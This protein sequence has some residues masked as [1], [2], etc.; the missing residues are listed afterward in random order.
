M[1]DRLI[2]AAANG[3]TLPGATSQNIE[4]IADQASQAASLGAKL[5]LFP[6]LSLTGFL[7]NHPESNHAAWLREALSFAR[8]SAERL[9][10]PAVTTLAR[11]AQQIGIYIAAGILEDAGNVLY[12]THVL[13][14]P[15]G[16]AG[17]WRK[18]HIPMFEMPFYNG[19]SGPEVID[20][21]IGRI[22]ANICFDTLLPESTRL[23]AVQNV[24]IVLFPFAA[25]PPP[26]TPAGWAA[27]AGPALRARCQ[28]N[29]VFGVAVNY[30][31]QV[32]ALGVGQNFPGGGMIVGPRGEVLAEQTNPG[33][34]L[35]HELQASDLRAA[36]AEPEYLFRF[37]RPE[38]YGPLT[39]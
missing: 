39:R 23:L 9:D 22:G 30:S 19:G 8:N 18:M 31:G 29:G 5:V 35:L 1:F 3:T 12:N 21:P 24:E 13:V 27:W 38:L 11:A 32:A 17:Y 4:K 6:E 16:L 14:G 20:T 33:E 10:G 34:L 25:D 37:R 2:A 36:R 26:V 28:E 7:P 15:Q